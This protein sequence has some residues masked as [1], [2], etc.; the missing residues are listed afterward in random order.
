MSA[1][2]DGPASTF[3]LRLAEMARLFSKPTV[4]VL[5]N[6]DNLDDDRVLTGLDLLARHAPPSLH[7]VMCGRQP[8]RLRLTKLR[9]S[10]GLAEIG[11]AALRAALRLPRLFSLDVIKGRARAW[12]RSDDVA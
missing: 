5:D 11:P 9:T 10:G 2:E 8:P 1:L 4:I 3:P 6:A 7:L 12:S